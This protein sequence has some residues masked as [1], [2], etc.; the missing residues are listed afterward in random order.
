MNVKCNSG[1][2]SEHHIRADL[3]AYL[4]I[5]FFLNALDFKLLLEI[6][7]VFNVYT[8]SDC[9]CYFRLRLMA[10]VH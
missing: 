3:R 9:F 1:K 8:T 2:F 10:M 4:L 7:E 6:H 5:F